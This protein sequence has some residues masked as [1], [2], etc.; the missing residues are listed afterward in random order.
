MRDGRAERAVGGALRIDMDPL[1]VS[2]RVREPVDAVL[3][4]E[5][6]P[7]RAKLLAHPRVKFGK[8]VDNHQCSWIWG[9]IRRALLRIFPVAVFGSSSTKW[10]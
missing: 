9:V 6:S 2:G 8:S 5:D 7:A 1:M 3:V 4:D 10:M